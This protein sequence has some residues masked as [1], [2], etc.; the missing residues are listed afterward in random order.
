MFSGIALALG[1]IALIGSIL[2]GKLISWDTA[3]TETG[4]MDFLVPAG[5]SDSSAD[6]DSQSGRGDV[7]TGVLPMVPDHSPRPPVYDEE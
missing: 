3:R 4:D 2:W 5:R 7:E 6:Y 1:A